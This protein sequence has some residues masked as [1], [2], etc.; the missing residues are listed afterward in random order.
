MIIFLWCI[1]FFSILH[2]TD[3][4]I[5]YIF[6]SESLSLEIWMNTWTYKNKWTAWK[7][8]SKIML[9]L[10]IVSQYNYLFYKFMIK[11][12]NSLI[13]WLV[14]KYSST[15]TFFFFFNDQFNQNKYKINND[16]INKFPKSLVI[17][18]FSKSF[19]RDLKFW[20]LGLIIIFY[21]ILMFCV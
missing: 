9:N 11:Q 10:V 4:G 15:K 5:S 2:L 8:A 20:L 6:P 14:I 17:W 1:F 3:L 12:C 7:V 19:I 21:F 18:F 13:L 16:K